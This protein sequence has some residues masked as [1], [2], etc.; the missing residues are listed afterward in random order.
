MGAAKGLWGDHAE[1][2]LVDALRKVN[3]RSIP[4][5]DNTVK[6]T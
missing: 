2:T 4:H 3:C 6:V 5:L 1:L